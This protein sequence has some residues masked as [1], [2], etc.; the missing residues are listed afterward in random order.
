[1]VI[2][3]AYV[4]NYF[5]PI[6][7]TAA[8]GP[9]I[10][11][12]LHW[13]GMDS[14]DL[15]QGLGAGVVPVY[16]I[17]DGIIVSARNDVT[18][19]DPSGSDASIPGTGNYIA[20]KITE[21]CSLQGAYVTY[22]H[23]HPNE[24]QLKAGAT[25]KK[26]QQIGLV[27]NTGHSTGPHLHIQIREGT[28]G[29]GGTQI[30]TSRVKPNVPTN[31]DR[32][33]NPRG[34]TDYLFRCAQPY[35][36]KADINQARIACTVGIL[37]GGVLG[38]IGMEEVIA[39]CYNRIGSSRFE[40]NTFYKIVSAPNQFEVY[41]KNKSLFD[42]GGYSEEKL[43]QEYPEL[44]LFANG[45]LNGNISLRSS[46]GW[47]SGYN[48]KIADTYYFNSSGPYITG[49]LFYRRNGGFCHWYGNINCGGRTR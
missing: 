19:A 26:G 33:T 48:S 7:E 28:W 46:I 40:G 43:T 21:V 4:H 16:S 18:R 5:Y 47:A 3:M 42:N 8:R 1:M 24:G 37:E 23:L 38:L 49:Q 44:W 31:P 39:T 27:G 17:C 6:Q 14:L 9:T 32:R 34:A 10:V 15:G 25:V 22:M 11:P 30:T 36:K 13:D 29:R 41:S 2:K 20:V 45:L 35:Y 12:N